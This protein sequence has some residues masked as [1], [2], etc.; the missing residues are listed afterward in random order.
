MSAS[1]RKL[2]FNRA[3]AEPQQKAAG[4]AEGLLPARSGRS[5]SLLNQLVVALQ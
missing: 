2:P 1:G 3:L 4:R 5:R